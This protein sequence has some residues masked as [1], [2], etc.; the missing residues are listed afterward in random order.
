MTDII[1]DLVLNVHLSKAQLTSFLDCNFFLNA[2]TVSE[3]S[4]PQMLLSK[5][6]DDSTNSLCNG[7]YNGHRSRFR[8]G[9]HGICA[10]K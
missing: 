9:L 10:E 6:T 2:S 4:L 1:A 8:I 5:L 7:L 3:Y